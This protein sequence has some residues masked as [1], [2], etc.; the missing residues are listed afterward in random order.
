LQSTRY[1]SR[2]WHALCG[3]PSVRLGSAMEGMDEAS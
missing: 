3:V 2:I 1:F